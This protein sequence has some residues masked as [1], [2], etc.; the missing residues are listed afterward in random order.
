M[1]T[2]IRTYIHTHETNSHRA[3]SR[4]P[5]ANELASPRPSARVRLLSIRN[6]RTTVSMKREVKHARERR[7]E[8]QIYFVLEA[9]KRARA[10]SPN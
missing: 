5:S 4:G 6:G 3:G 1:H 2:Y 8:Q 7:R 10:F 9:G